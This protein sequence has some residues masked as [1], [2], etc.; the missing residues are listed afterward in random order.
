MQDVLT[1][2]FEQHSEQ[3]SGSENAD[4]RKAN[5]QTCRLET[6]RQAGTHAGSQAHVQTCTHT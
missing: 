3:S 6:R 5:R 4:G 1:L 2:K